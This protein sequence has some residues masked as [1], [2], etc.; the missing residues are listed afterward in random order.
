MRTSTFKKT[1]LAANIAI[2]LGGAVSVG[3]LAAEAADNNSNETANIEKIEV[4]GMRASM[5]ASVNTKRF[6][7]P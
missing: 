5:K 1:A 4:R 6:Q 7:M 3:A 2:L